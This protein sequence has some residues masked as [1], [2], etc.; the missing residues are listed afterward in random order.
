MLKS[1]N[2]TVLDVVLSSVIEG[3]EINSDSGNI[4]LEDGFNLLLEDGG[5]ILL[6]TS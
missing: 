6:Q 1:I 4:L 2:N 5:L 3:D